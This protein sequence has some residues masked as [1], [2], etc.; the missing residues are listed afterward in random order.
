MARAAAEG[1]R[2]RVMSHFKKATKTSFA[3]KTFF[4]FALLGFFLVLLKI[5]LIH[6]FDGS[7]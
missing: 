6:S 5:L 7:E 2:G 3:A 1:I 4:L